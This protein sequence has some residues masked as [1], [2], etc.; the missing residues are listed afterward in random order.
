LQ[1]EVALILTK[2]N[3]E[4]LGVITSEKVSVLYEENFGKKS[5]IS[6]ISQV[7]EELYWEDT[8]EM[9]EQLDSDREI[10]SYLI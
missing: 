4:E 2:W 5:T 8:V 7:L 1:E 10:S 3:L 9:F 6:E